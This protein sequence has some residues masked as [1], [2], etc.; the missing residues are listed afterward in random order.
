MNDDDRKP[1]TDPSPPMDDFA[2]RTETIPPGPADEL[3]VPR[4]MRTIHEQSTGFG[5]SVP[6][7]MP[8]WLREIESRW[9]A[10]LDKTLAAQE[11]TFVIAIELVLDANEKRWEKFVNS[12]FDRK[13]LGPKGGE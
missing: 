6:P 4:A 10:T 12:L 11:K 2:D 1:E 3:Y 8:A 9:I 5:E 13:L 7:E